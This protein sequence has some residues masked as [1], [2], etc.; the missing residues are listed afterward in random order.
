MGGSVGG[1]GAAGDPLVADQAVE[2]LTLP[3]IFAKFIET[4]IYGIS[5]IKDAR[6]DI[7]PGGRLFLVGVY[8]DLTKTE[9][10]M[11]GIYDSRRPAP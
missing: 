8:A 11:C 9:S 3:G 2:R 5:G 10:F 7:N 6:R 4:V 1:T